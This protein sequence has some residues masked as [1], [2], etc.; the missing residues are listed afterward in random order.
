MEREKI[1]ALRN[2]EVDLKKMRN[3]KLQSAEA[4][5]EKFRKEKQSADNE[6]EFGNLLTEYGNLCKSV[7][8]Q[9][10]SDRKRQKEELEQ[11]LKDGRNKKRK[12]VT[13]R[14]ANREDKAYQ[15]LQE[16]KKEV[17]KELEIV[18][19]LIQ[20]IDDEDGKI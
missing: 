8:S 11:K 5:L 7:D 18:K 20:P 4:K 13:E 15:E 10:E 17:E 2:I 9:V 6:I 3:N 19:G 1:S 14:R 12:E 16:G